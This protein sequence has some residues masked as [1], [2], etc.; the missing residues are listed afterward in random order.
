VDDIDNVM[1]VVDALEARKAAAS[2]PAI[3]TDDGEI[4]TLSTQATQAGR[5][6]VGSV[7]SFFGKINVAAV[8]LTGDLKVGDTIE[9]ENEE[10]AIRQ[11][12]GSMQIDRKDVTEAYEGDDVG[13]K[14]SVPVTKGSSVYRLG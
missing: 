2:A 12:V 4:G 8:M 11:K 3:Q 6:L 14:L 13:I 9:I 7:D 1:E 5:T 10:Y